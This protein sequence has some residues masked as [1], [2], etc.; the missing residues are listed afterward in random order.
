MSTFVGFPDEGLR[1]L[2]ELALNNNK[3][4]FDSH[5]RLFRRRRTCYRRAF[6]QPVW[7]CLRCRWEP[8]DRGPGQQSDSNGESIVRSDHNRRRNRD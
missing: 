4:W 6:E 1:F 8:V 3:Q 5:R 2:D 7:D